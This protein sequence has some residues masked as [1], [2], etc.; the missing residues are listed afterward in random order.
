MAMKIWHQSFTVL[1]N[2]PAYEAAIQQHLGQVLRSDTE[3]VLHGQ[4]PGTYPGNYP[5][6]DLVYSYL[7]QIHG[8]QW[9]AAAQAAERGGF[10]AF[11]MCTLMDPMIHE[12]RT[13]VEIPIVAYGE[14]CFHLSS[15]YGKRFGVLLFMDRAAP[16]YL[17]QIRRYGLSGNCAGVRGSGVTFK[18][19]MAGYSEPGPVVDRFSDSVR[20]F[21]K[22]T[23]ADVII[24][25][26]LVM[27]MMLAMHG[28]NRV[29][30]V[31]I[32][33]GLAMTMK[34]AEMAVDLRRTTGIAHSRHGFF[35]AAPP[36]E[37]IEYV[38]EF[39]GLDRLG[40]LA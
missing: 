26:E 7:N 16:L 5:G 39:Y 13:L 12:I 14:A 4:R 24:P 10:D 11:A 34:I 37:R 23:G 2:V 36:K 27:S 33:D 40:G 6:D 29:D 32:M 35:N 9:V 30:D 15:M 31:P 18:E 1:Q 28:V 21:V 38:T 20:Q 19:V 3:V 8:N 25:G 22:E 17:E